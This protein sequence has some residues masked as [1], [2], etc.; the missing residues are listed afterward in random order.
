M[1]CPGSGRAAQ[2]VPRTEHR[3]QIER[4]LLARIQAE[5]TGTGILQQVA[6]WPI[7][8]T[9]D[10]LFDPIVRAQMIEPVSRLCRVSIGRW[11][12]DL[13]H[14]L[15]QERSERLEIPDQFFCT[16]IAVRE[17]HHSLRTVSSCPPQINGLE[18]EA[19][20]PLAE[21]LMVAVDEF[22][23]PLAAHP[24]RPGHHIRVHATADAMGC[25]VDGTRETGVLQGES[26][27]ESRNSRAD[28]SDVG[29]VSSPL[30]AHKSWMHIQTRSR[31]HWS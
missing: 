5:V 15:L 24:I 31:S 17:I 14:L 11:K 2:Q 13:L 8:S 1:H 4:T 22:P 28:D 9:R 16:V 18:A 30:E 7:V 26:C 19:L 21:G 6:Q 23:T 27:A 25:F 10:V 3:D 20:D 29:H 12:A